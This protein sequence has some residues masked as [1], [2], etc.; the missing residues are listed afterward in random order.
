[1]CVCVRGSGLWVCDVFYTCEEATKA[2]V[3]CVT[4]VNSWIGAEYAYVC[5]VGV[6]VR[7]Q[8][9]AGLYEAEPVFLLQP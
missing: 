4:N 2:V 3:A 6:S 7:C 9:Q 1:M 5:V 8:E